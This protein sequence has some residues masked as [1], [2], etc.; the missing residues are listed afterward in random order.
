[1]WPQTVVTPQVG[2]MGCTGIHEKQQSL[3]MKYPWRNVITPCFQ[4]FP[5]P[6]SERKGKILI[7]YYLQ[8]RMST[9]CFLLFIIRHSVHYIVCFTFL[10]I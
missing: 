10:V 5:R 7:V 1:M 8:L 3:V 2:L 9:N 6:Y 4:G